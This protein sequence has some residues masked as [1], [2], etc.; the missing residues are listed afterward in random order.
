MAWLQTP[1][2]LV[3]NPRSGSSF[4]FQVY[5]PKDLIHHFDGIKSFRISLQS[6]TKTLS[7]KLSKILSAKIESLFYEIRA[8]MRSLTV[9]DIKEILRIE[10]RKSI[11]H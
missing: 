1:S 5:I 4:F 3:K 9:E 2:R 11:L 8:G 7:S 10:I 6:G